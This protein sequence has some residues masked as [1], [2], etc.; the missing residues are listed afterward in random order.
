MQHFGYS[1]LRGQVRRWQFANKRSTQE[2]RAGGLTGCAVAPRND[3]ECKYSQASRLARRSACGLAADLDPAIALC[4][5][6]RLLAE[7]EAATLAITLANI[8][9][10]RN[11]FADSIPSLCTVQARLGYQV[12][13]CASSFL[14]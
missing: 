14:L 7:D 1:S 10:R 3:G 8:R 9:Y 13:G 2:K 6:D 4:D 12:C 5:P 11:E